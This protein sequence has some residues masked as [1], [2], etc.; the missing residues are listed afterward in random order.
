MTDQ[1]PEPSDPWAPPERP[2]VDPGKGRGASGGPGGPGLHDQPTIAGMPG[3]TAPGPFG[4]TAQPFDTAAQP[5][6]TAPQAFGATAQPFGATA[7][8]D[9]AGS[10]GQ[11]PG[12]AYGYPAQPDPAGYGYPGGQLPGRPAPYT[13]WAPT[14]P[15]PSNGL[16]ITGFVLGLLSV[17]A[18]P[19]LVGPVA[20]G[21]A[22]VVFGALGRGKANRGEAGNGGLA[23][24]GVILGSVGIVIGVLVTLAFFL[25]PTFD[26]VDRYGPYEDTGVQER[27]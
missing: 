2:A 3:A 13:P 27:I 20:L 19:T 21:I 10:W 9:P 18:C 7:P 1:S 6:D 11:A 14:P 26:D 15:P 23:L 25:G 17:I 8:I 16:A 12:P 24:A 22:G 4:A 5:F